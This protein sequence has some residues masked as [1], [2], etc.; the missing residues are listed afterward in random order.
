MRKITWGIVLVVLAIAIHFGLDSTRR[1][2]PVHTTGVIF[3]TGTSSG[4]GNHAVFE[5]AKLNYT[6]F[7]SVRKDTD[8][9]E[10]N[11]QAQKQNLQNYVKPIIMDVV[12]SDQIKSALAEITKFVKAKNLPFVGLVNNAGISTRYPVELL[13]LDTA[14]NLMDINFF[15]VLEITQQFLPL[16]REHKSRIL[17]VSSISAVASLPGRAIYCASKRAIEA[18]VDTLRLEMLA[19]DVSVT[20]I[21][22]GYVKSSIS[23]KLPTYENVPPEQYDLYRKYLDSVIPENKKDRSH[24]P[25]PEVTSEAIVH[26]LTDPYPHTRYYMGYTGD[27][28]P[29]VTAILSQLLPDHLLDYIKLKRYN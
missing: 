24:A 1:Q 17:V 15:G 2:Y 3:I 29:Y 10:L 28:P 7:C 13:P 9:K 4:I 18:F 5:L 12:N 14:R 27:F 8:V 20:S 25:G 19:F 16:I 11:S 21:L 23:D 26:A 6:V 22:P